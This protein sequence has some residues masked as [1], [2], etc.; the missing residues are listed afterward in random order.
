[1]SFL[2][3]IWTYPWL[4]AVLINT[5]I[6]LLGI[7]L[8]QKALT[9]AGVIHAWILGVI[10]WGCL[11]WRGYGV[12]SIY[13]L[14]GTAVTK[15]GIQQKQAKGIA[16]KRGGARGPENVW[17]SALTGAICALGYGLWAHPFWWLAYCA[18]FAAKLADTTS[19]EVGKAYGKKTFLIT[20]LQ[21]V[22]AGTEG[23]ISVEGTL[24]GYGAALG[25]SGI[26][27]GLTGEWIGTLLSWQWVGICALAAIMATTAESWIG[28]VLQPKLD[29]L[30]NEVVNGIQTTLAALIAL[31]LGLL[32]LN[33]RILN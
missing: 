28:V 31:L 29:W 20:T 26:C 16:E 25:L 3:L 8:P 27:W 12:V 33:L 15:I 1:M 4:Q 13:F 22:P 32:I 19:S 2:D 21:P 10:V 11:G 30:T 5:P 23:A 7:L 6:A 14:L 9:R 18:S 24:A 17:G